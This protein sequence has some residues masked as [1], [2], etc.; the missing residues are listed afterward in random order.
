MSDLSAWAGCAVPKD[1][2]LAGRFVR[3]DPFAAEDGRRLWDAFGGLRTNDL[4][5]FF[6][7]GPYPEPAR[8][9]HW[10]CAAQRDWRT[11]VYRRIDDG[12]VCGMASY[13]RIDAAN[14]SIEVGSVAHAPSVQRT[15]IATEAHYLMARHVFDDL[16]YRRYEWKCHNENVPSHVAAKR[17][18]FVFEG[19]FRQHIVSK[20]ANRDTAWYSIIDKEWPV[21]REA[22]ERWLDPSN[23]DAAGNQNARLEDI[24]EALRGGQAKG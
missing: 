14:G 9:T 11:L 13:M 6:P 12:S 16:G 24:R 20:G 18:G 2:H 8:F 3:L 17:Y 4:I 19:I 23:F 10:L 22:F 15:P 7:N 1:V 5:R 21:V